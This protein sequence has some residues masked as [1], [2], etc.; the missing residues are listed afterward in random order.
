M[1]IVSDYITAKVLWAV[2][3]AIGAII[4]GA[5]RG[6]TGKRHDDDLEP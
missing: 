1:R 4:Y 5:Y 6:W 2:V 3:L